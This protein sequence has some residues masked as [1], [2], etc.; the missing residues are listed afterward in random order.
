MSRSADH[1]QKATEWYI[2]LTSGQATEDDYRAWR[3]WKNA[4]P[5]H[6]HAWQTLEA[7]TQPFSAVDKSLGLMTLN[8]MG[9]STDKNSVTKNTVSGRRQALKHLSVLLIIGASGMLA[10][11]TRPWQLVMVD[12]STDVGERRE[13]MLQDGTRLI[14]NTGSAIAINFTDTQRLVTLYKGEVLIETGHEHHQPYRPLIVNSEDGAVTALGTR[15]SLRQHTSHTSVNLFD[16]AL[17][18]KPKQA[19]SGTLLNAGES[20]RFDQTGI[21]QKT[22]L[23]AGADAW[24]TGFLIAD[25]MP[26]GKFIE[27]LARYKSGTLRCD[28]Q[29]ANLEI[30]GAYPIHDI[31]SVLSSIS[32]HLPVRIETFTRYWVV[33]KAA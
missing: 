15:F 24:S 1:I 23:T 26:L 17:N 7:A 3:S 16:G 9:Q 8:N 25:K 33:V 2:Q 27:E 19:A 6:E 28:P 29:V 21:L 20:I 13:I 14:L 30:S 31:D 32:E 12:H 22:S 4:Q 5:E 18:I 11:R 10:Y